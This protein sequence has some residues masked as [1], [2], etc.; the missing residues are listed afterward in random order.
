L[1]ATGADPDHSLD[2][3]RIITFGVSTRARLL[4]VAH[5]VSGDTIRIR[6]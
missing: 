4:I 2:D 5:T 1:S 6:R 3:E